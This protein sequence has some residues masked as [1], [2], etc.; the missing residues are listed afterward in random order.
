[1]NRNA[2]YVNYDS[3]NDVLYIVMGEGMEEEY[4]EVAPGVNVELDA[5]GEIIGIEILRASEFLRPVAVPLLQ[6]IKSG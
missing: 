6:R 4:V 5:R 1:M 2:P 3:Q